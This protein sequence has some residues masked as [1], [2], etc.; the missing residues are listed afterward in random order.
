MAHAAAPEKLTS[1]SIDPEEVEKFS[2]MAAEWWDPESKF[3]PLHKFNPARIGY[4]RDALISHFNLEAGGEPL[5]G[6][7]LLDIGCG[8]GLIAEP[9]ARLGASVTAVDAAE[10]NIKTAKVHAEEQ[11]LTIDYRHG[12]AEQLL[13]QGKA[14]FDV[15]LNLE[16]VEHVAEPDQFLRDC[17][18]LLKPGGLMIVASIN[19]TSKA[20]VFAIFGAEWVMR[21]LPRGTH[22]FD[23]LIKPEEVRSALSAE[24]LD[25]KTPVG[26]SYNPLKDEFEITSDASV[27]YMMTAVKA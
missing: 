27:N 4:I 7:K 26:V 19:R 13:E 15:V 8:G 1:P 6:L 18:K 25:V 24:G 12:T 10:P 21:W 22:R 20:F 5:K 16:V 9:M 2:R 11:G 3:K 23:K 17:A 14:Q